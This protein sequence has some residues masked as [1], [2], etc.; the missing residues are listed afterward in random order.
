M[1]EP[2]FI[3][4]A[5]STG[6]R[7]TVANTSAPTASAD[8][9]GTFATIAT[10]ESEAGLRIDRI[11]FRANA[12]TAANKL[13]IFIDGGGKRLMVHEIPVVAVSM[14]TSAAAWGHDWILDPPLV[15]QEGYSLKFAPCVALAAG[16]DA[17]VVCGGEL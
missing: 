2:K 12:T 16:F 17:V 8:C 3:Q 4:T 1:S 6:G 11:H 13:R 7:A 14:S 15:L 10:C 5:V 9:S